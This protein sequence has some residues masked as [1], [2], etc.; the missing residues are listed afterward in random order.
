M[1]GGQVG[2]L[3]GIRMGLASAPK[4]TNPPPLDAPRSQPSVFPLQAWL[5]P[6]PIGA[7]KTTRIPFVVGFPNRVVHHHHHHHYHYHHQHQ[8][9]RV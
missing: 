4:P 7:C 3:I 6:S 8:G 2:S 1:D 9:C 5:L